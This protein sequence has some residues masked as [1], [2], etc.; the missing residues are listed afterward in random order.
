[1]IFMPKNRII[2]S[3][4]GNGATVEI[5]ILYTDSD[6]GFTLQR[7]TSTPGY[8][9]ERH[10]HTEREVVYVVK[11][12]LVDETGEYPAGKTKINEKGFIHRSHSGPEGCTIL[13]W[14]RGDHAPVEK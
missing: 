2:Q 1:M 11:G 14:S 9:S 5:E 7:Q 12:I 6:S 10:D 4:N 3:S 8:L 13:V